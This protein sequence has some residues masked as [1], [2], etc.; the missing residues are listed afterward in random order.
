[1]HRHIGAHNN[2]ENFSNTAEPHGF[3]RKAEEIILTKKKK[4]GRVREREKID[5]RDHSSWKFLS[6]MFTYV[7]TSVR[8]INIGNGN[9]AA[10]C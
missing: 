7:I 6:L 2:S 10:S 1:M 9:Y 3:Q 8:A 4:R 5:I